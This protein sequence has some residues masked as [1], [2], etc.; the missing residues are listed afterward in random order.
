[1]AR[2]IDDLQLPVSEVDDLTVFHG[3]CR[4][5]SD[6][7]EGFPRKICRRTQNLFRNDKTLQLLVAVS[8]GQPLDGGINIIAHDPVKLRIPPDMIGVVMRVQN[9]DRKRGQRLCA[10]A[11]IADSQPRIPEQ[12]GFFPKNEIGDDQLTLPV[13]KQRIDIPRKRIDPE[14]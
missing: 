5:F 7:E 6:D 9:G 1:M 11:D 2:R 10:C 4:R 14:S 12:R 8:P 13:F 3:G